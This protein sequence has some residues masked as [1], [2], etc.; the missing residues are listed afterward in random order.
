MSVV[1]SEG[2]VDLDLFVL[3][4]M[5]TSNV[6]RCYIRV[7]LVLSQVIQLPGIFMS[8]MCIMLTRGIICETYKRSSLPI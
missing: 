8:S 5:A 7:D 1:A 4:I 3:V 2:D 6:P